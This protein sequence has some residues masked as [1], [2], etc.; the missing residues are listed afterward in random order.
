MSKNNRPII[1]RILAFALCLFIVIAAPIIIASKYS[2]K[3]QS[4]EDAVSMLTIWQIDSFEGGKG[5]RASYLRN[6]GNEL[7][8]KSDCYVNVISLTADAA[9]LNLSSG[10]IPDLISY[11]AGTYGLEGYIIGDTPY[12]TWAHGGYCFLTIDENADFTDI[13]NQNTVINIGVDNIYG[14]AALLCGIGG[15]PTDKPTGAYVSLINGEFK[16]L[17]GTQRDIFRLTTRGIAFKIKP[18]QEYNDLYQNISI[19]TT[20]SLQ[21]IYAKKFID[22]LLSHYADLNKLGLMAESKIYDD[23]M[24]K[25][26]LIDYSCKL[27]TPIS[28]NTR[29]QI[30]EA[31]SK[32]D[33]ILLKNLIK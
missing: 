13:T 29:E 1:L 4:A 9:R 12:Y 28:K 20:N 22:A 23:V 27:T 8:D 32:S 33:I 19:T 7:Y 24:S 14:A 6:I 10:N 2:N 11:G 25:M 5:S 30:F 26:E 15:A 17:L 31:I 18:I 3:S 16:Y 21:Q